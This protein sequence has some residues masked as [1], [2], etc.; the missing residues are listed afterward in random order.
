M[1]GRR[2]A[3]ASL[4]SLQ[5]HRG[6]IFEWI[7]DAAE[8][9]DLDLTIAHGGRLAPADAKRLS[10]RAAVHDFVDYA[11]ILPQSD[12]A[13][14]HGGMN[15]VLDTL[16]HGVPLVVVPL[17]YEQG[18]IAARVRR[19][20]AGT[21]CRPLAHAGRLEAAIAA[22]MNDPSHAQAADKVREEIVAAGG[23]LVA[24]DIVEQVVRTRGPCLNA[25]AISR[26]RSLASFA[27]GAD[28]QSVPS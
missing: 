26:D 13:I 9:L 14:M 2:R 21:V 28:L 25:A 5:G 15:G 11:E 27:L 1:Q 10:R 8:V 4:G 23:V 6:E 22:V 3:F 16:A 20:G 7:A 24:A 12:V 18:A 19:A 17:A